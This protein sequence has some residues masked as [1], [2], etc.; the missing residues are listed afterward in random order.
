MG[1]CNKIILVFLALLVSPVYAYDLS[2]S[3][4]GWKEKGDEGYY[5]T[6]VREKK[7]SGTGEV[8]MIGVVDGSPQKYFA[9]VGDYDNFPEFMPYLKYVKKQHSEKVDENKTYNYVFFYFASPVVADR[10]YNLKLLDEKNA[11]GKKGTYKSSWTLEKGTYRKTPADP[12]ISKY[13]KSGDKAV[14]TAFNEGY[15]LLEPLEDGK[16][17]KITYYVW[18]NPGGSI[19]DFI[20]NK[21]N[22]VALP[23]LM[24]AIQ[25][26][27]KNPKYNSAN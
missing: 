1:H 15:W 16:K 3:D 21:A 4:L 27:I 11:N 24:K 23:K 2:P 13:V 19:P 12:E 6:Y 17:T 25:E 20:A 9:V 22:T 26:R 5:K 10:F 7:D 14:E 8:L 18:T